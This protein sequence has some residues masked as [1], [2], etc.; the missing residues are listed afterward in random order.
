MNLLEN[1][2]YINL[3][4]REDRRKHIVEQLIVLGG[5]N[6]ERFPAVLANSGA[7]GCSI[8]HIKSLE[9]AKS[10]EWEYVCIV[11]DDFRCINTDRFRQSLSDFEKKSKQDGLEWDILLLGGNNCPP[12][13]I[14]IDSEGNNIDYCVQITN[15]QSAIGY[16]VRKSYLDILIQNFR[17]GVAQLIRYPENKREFAVDMY[18]KRLQGSGKWYLL[19][20]LTITQVV[21]YSDI[22]KQEKNYDYLMLDINKPWLFQ[23]AQQLEV[24]QNMKCFKKKTISMDFS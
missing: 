10:K 5:I 6:I 19:V 1:V 9:Y 4:S 7:V 20:P 21:S 3:E 14:P 16:V 22:E 17:E 12:Y 23:P 11:E 15:C 8:S 24:L 13:N 18:W 2:L